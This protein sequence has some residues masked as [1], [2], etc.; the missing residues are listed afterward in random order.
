MNLMATLQSMCFRHARRMSEARDCSLSYG[1]IKE[2]TFSM[3]V[4]EDTLLEQSQLSLCG[5]LSLARSE[6]D[7]PI[8]HGSTPQVPLRL[9]HPMQRCLLCRLFDAKQCLGLKLYVTCITSGKGLNH[10]QAHGTVDLTTAN[11]DVVFPKSTSSSLAAR[12]HAASLV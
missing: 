2:L 10:T 12:R 4:S 3:K 8:R 9:R 7:L 6:C 11:I 5:R 1:P